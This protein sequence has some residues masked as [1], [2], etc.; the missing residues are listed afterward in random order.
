MR[1]GNFGQVYGTP[2]HTPVRICLLIQ[3]FGIIVRIIAKKNVSNYL[4]AVLL[5][6]QG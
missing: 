1:G 3:N 5:N 2:G 4:D 6:I